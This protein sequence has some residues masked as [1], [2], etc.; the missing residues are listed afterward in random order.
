LELAYIRDSKVFERDGATR[1]G[2]A[3]A[4][5]RGLT[6][7]FLFYGTRMIFYVRQ[8]GPTS[9]LKGGGLCWSGM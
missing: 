9:R 6:G 1:R 8:V 3:R 2:K 5:L 7:A 4:E